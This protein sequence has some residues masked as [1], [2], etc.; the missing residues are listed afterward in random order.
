ME[1]LGKER[2]LDGNVVHQGIA[3]YGNKGSTDQH[4]YVQQLREGVPNFLRH[5]R[6]GPA[7][8]R[9]RERHRG[10]AT[11]SP[12]ATTCTGSC[13]A[14]AS[15]LHDNG[16]PVADDHRGRDSRPHSRG[17]ADRPVRA[18]R[19]TVRRR[20]VRDQRLPPAGRRGGQEGG[21]GR[22]RAAAQADR[23][24]VL[25]AAAR[26]GGTCTELADRSP[27]PRTRWKRCSMMLE[28]LS[29]QPRPRRDPQPGATP[30]R[31]DATR[32]R[33]RQ[34]E[35]TD[36]GLRRHR[37]RRRLGGQLGGGGGHRA[38]ARTLMINDGELGGLCI[39]RGCMPTKTLLASGAR[40]S[41]GQ[42]PRALR[43]AD[44]RDAYDGGLPRIVMQRKDGTPSRASRQAK[45]DSIESARLRGHPWTRAA[46]F[47]AGRR[48]RGRRTQAERASATSSP[49]GR[50]PQIPLRSRASTTCRC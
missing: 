8:A 4:A 32:G 30:V 31:Y 5:V 14:P 2:D 13:S 34:T 22:A 15:A 46:R 41:R 33:M 10:R 6:R 25:T 9:R 45:V 23:R 50:F 40:G 37:P 18:R 43:R 48:R 39:L 27:M 7:R 20:L 36:D 19:R 38:G 24:R 17:H 16:P 28:R 29:R 12:R 49:P 42:S 35:R 44:S 26:G 21:G 47:A 11:A 1:S 3:V